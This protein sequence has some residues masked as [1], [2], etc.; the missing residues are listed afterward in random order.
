MPS[1]EVS[2]YLTGSKP[3]SGFQR[4]V[5]RLNGKPVYIIP[6]RKALVR[7]KSGISRFSPSTSWLWSPTQ[8]LAHSTANFVLLGGILIGIYSNA[9]LG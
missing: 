2:I 7:L 8:S 1:H 6:S 9:D 4:M 3:G 5:Q